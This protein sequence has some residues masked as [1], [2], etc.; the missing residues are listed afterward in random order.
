MILCFDEYEVDPERLELRRG[1]L[2]LRADPVVVRMLAALAS[3]AGDLV[4]NEEL[5]RRVWDGRSVSD[6][7]VGVTIT[8]LRRTLGHD[9]G[10][11]EYVLNEHGRGYRFV[12]PV[13]KLSRALQPLLNPR[14]TQHSAFGSNACFVGRESVMKR[15]RS[16]LSEACSGHGSVVLLTGEPGI[17]KT[18]LVEQLAREATATGLT[19]AWG[20]CLE[21]GD[22]PP[23]WP[24]Q[25]LV[26]DLLARGSGVRPSSPS[27]E[28]APA[29][30][31]DVLSAHGSKPMAK[32]AA[33]ES[34]L[35][36]F[37]S[38]SRN[39]P[40][41]LVLDDL[42]RADAA[43]LELLRMW[44]DQVS[45]T[46]VL[47]VCTMRNAESRH[48]ASRADLSY[49]RGH[50]N[51]LR[52]PVERLAEHAVAAYVKSQLGD[53]DDRFAHAVHCKSQGNPF[54]MVE[55]VRELL[56]SDTP[57][58]PDA[59]EVSHAALD[60]VRP[61][62]LELDRATSGL[63]S[64]AAVLGT[65]FDLAT[66]AAVAE[67]P[68]T[69]VMPLLDEAIASEVVSTAPGS[70]TSFSFTHDL[71]RQAL[72]DSN[73]PA[74]RR[75]RHLQV[76][77]V[78]EKQRESGR[79]V[80]AAAL[81]YHLHAALPDGEIEATVTAC[82][83]AANEAARL[84]AY[85]DSV[86]HL[87]HAL[88][89]LSFRQDATPQAHMELLLRQAF[90]ARVSASPELE[91]AVRA[92]VELARQHRA[93]GFMTHAGTLL[94]LHPG[95]PPWGG[96]RAI[97]EEALSWLGPDDDELR[98][99]LLAHLAT[100]APLSYD[101]Q[102]SAEQLLE[103]RALCERS[104]SGFGRFSVLSAELYLT[105]GAA[106]GESA[107]AI[108][109]SFDGF[110]RHPRAQPFAAVM[111]NFHRA[112]TALQRGEVV[113]SN[114][115]LAAATARCRDLGS[116]ELLWHAERFQLHAILNKR[117]DD[118]AR[119]SLRTL[120]AR[121]RLYRLV[122]TELF[123]AYDEL[124]ILGAD[125]T[126]GL[127][128]QCCAPN[129]D[130][131]PSVWSMKVRLLAAAGDHDGARRLLAEVAPERLTAL[132]RDRDYLGTLGTL[133]HAALLLDEQPYLNALYPLLTAHADKFAVHVSFLC[134]GSIA[135]LCGKI[136]AARGD[137]VAARAHL[138]KGSAM[139]RQAGLALWRVDSRPVLTDVS[140]IPV[141]ARDQRAPHSR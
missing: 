19:V 18:R 66:L 118:E 7:V 47:L 119:A 30:E 24:V 117:D 34:L 15:L 61:R 114:A 75:R 14:D 58:D 38:A 131:P 23:L 13:A 32:Y 46:R 141:P 59:L 140:V 39:T 115:A 135:T 1:G 65:T 139:M 4:T 111:L 92:V 64:F 27:G 8:R 17:G 9:A 102:A 63:L 16:A 123:I 44:V 99:I 82:S 49:L 41:L 74:L 90:D 109:R 132:P 67:Q 68:A 35:E 43:S 62:L 125:P 94:D 96:A 40:C 127:L 50:R 79:S 103:A 106:A 91:S 95:F 57:P 26:R 88:E 36:V 97:L 37:A 136:A 52:I 69:T 112:I 130:D 121:A 113:S 29:K 3:D 101:A 137:D 128:H 87:R 126:S 60:L 105:G 20:A 116:Q 134:E 77:R 22:A 84:C 80:T 98:A 73:A 81:A 53:A 72:Y 133:T 70:A 31:G 6:K 120:H 93:A 76:A 2:P 21:A 89:A 100:N 28:I 122:A 86:G 5:L 104:G 45:R 48:S 51:C 12:R 83:Q 78:L 55:C 54:Y 42:H 25:Q 33:L 108:E 129:C 110:C 107:I 56:L 11:R 71:M 85:A 124:L 138:A 10:V